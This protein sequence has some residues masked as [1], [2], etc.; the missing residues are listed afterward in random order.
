L[1]TQLAARRTY[2]DMHEDLESKA[3]SHL[4]L[5]FGGRPTVLA[6][7]TGMNRVTLRAKL[8]RHKEANGHTG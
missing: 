6:R 7:E 3:L 1:D 5:R 2:R 8:D 4:L